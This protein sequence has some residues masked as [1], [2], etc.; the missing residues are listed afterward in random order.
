[1]KM[2]NSKRY[3]EEDRIIKKYWFIKPDDRLFDNLMVFGFECGSGWFKLIEETFD[4]I[5][6]YLE[7][8]HPE[9]DS[10]IFQITQVKEKYGRLIIYV[11]S[12]V[13]EVYDILSRAERASMT[14]CEICGKPGKLVK[15]NGWYL[16]RCDKCLELFGDKDKID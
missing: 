14:I 11:S 5:K 8:N 7:T 15:Y 13:E 2:D 10:N 12:S 6:E 1:M 3:Q 16:T 4:R 9:I